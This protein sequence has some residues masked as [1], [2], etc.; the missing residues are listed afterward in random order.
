[1]VIRNPTVTQYTKPG[2]AL[3]TDDWTL[4]STSDPIYGALFFDREGR[5]AVS[6][7]VHPGGYRS[8]H[9]YIGGDWRW[10]EWS[11]FDELFTGEL[12]HDLTAP[13]FTKPR[14]NGK[15]AALPLLIHD[16]LRKLM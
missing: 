12:S 8:F 16:E 5:P 7:V 11:K 9:Y 13:H 3:I 1:M 10:A 4:G 15:K 6:V 2:R 14:S